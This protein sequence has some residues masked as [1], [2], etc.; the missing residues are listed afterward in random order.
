MNY[1]K[2]SNIPSLKEAAKRSRKPVSILYD[3]FN[4]P[5]EIGNFGNGKTYYVRTYGCQANERDGE[6][7]IGIL[8][9][10]G[11]SETQDMAQ[12]DIVILNTCA[13]R[14]NAEDKVFGEI[15]HMKSY[16][17]QKPDAIYCIC[18]C[19]V[20]QESITQKIYEKYP[21]VDLV[22]GTHNIHR[23]PNLIYEVYFNKKR[24]YEVFSYEGEVIENVPYK[25]MSN[26]KAWVNIMYGCDKFCT[27]CIVPFTRGK[28]RSRKKIDIINEVIQL[29]QLG[30]QE[31][32]LLGQNVNAYGKDLLEDNGNFAM[33]L[34]EVAETKIP[35]IRF[36][37]SHPWDFSHEMINII[38]QHDN[39]MPFIHLPVQSGDNEILRKMARRYTVEDYKKLYNEIRNAIPGVSITTD[40]IVGFPNESSEA[41]E[42]TIQL[43]EELKFDAAFTFIYS[44]RPGTPAAKME[45]NISL[46]TKH[47]RF[48]HLV[49][50]I[51]R[52][53]KE[54]NEKY[55]GQIVK[56]LVEGV[57]KRNK[58]ILSGYSESNKL[59]N[60]K[61]N[62]SSIGKIV[63]VKITNVKTFTLEGEEIDE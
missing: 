53:S 40:I 36:V 19:M 39:L 5:L 63:K 22:F 9:Q 21:C 28:Q 15:G 4:I 30:Y 57:S 2:L 50:V 46:D 7:I 54:R 37:T 20:Q 51:N 38:A 6:T 56:V 44:P 55:L 3:A 32:T 49:E 52:H 24:V 43:A 34:K 11:Y 29:K 14:E 17:T 41:F 31:I 8:E 45:D 60:F 61:G 13:I 33:L 25:R 48:N 26:L 27:Y 59:I 58:S 42:N 62:I 1:E 18:G 35:R 23:L 12:A 47:K 10:L 16:R